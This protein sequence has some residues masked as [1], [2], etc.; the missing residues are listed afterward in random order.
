VFAPN[1]SRTAGGCEVESVSDVSESLAQE[2]STMA[3]T[4]STEIRIVDF[5]IARIVVDTAGQFKSQSAV[6]RNAGIRALLLLSVNVSVLTSGLL[7]TV[8]QSQ[9]GAI[10]TCGL[11]RLLQ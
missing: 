9:C 4:E 11:S 2:T 1:G 7:R 8:A 3:T 10:V 6:R 5:F